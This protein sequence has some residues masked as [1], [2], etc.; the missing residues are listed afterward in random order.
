[1]NASYSYLLHNN[2]IDKIIFGFKDILHLNNIF[3]INKFKKLS[4]KKIILLS[5]L[6]RKNYFLNNKDLLY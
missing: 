6:E 5:E 3:K 2:N 1:M 4:K